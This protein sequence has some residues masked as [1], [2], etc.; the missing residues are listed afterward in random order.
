M[1]DLSL[2]GINPVDITGLALYLADLILRVD[3]LPVREIV[4]SMPKSAAGT[5]PSIDEN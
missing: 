3:Q 1:L 2:D 4:V 5:A